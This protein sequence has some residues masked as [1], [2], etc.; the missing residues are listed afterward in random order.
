MAVQLALAVSACSR[1]VPDVLQPLQAQLPPDVG[2]GPKVNVLPA[3]TLAV[4]VFKTTYAV[5]RLGVRV[6]FTAVPPGFIKEIAAY[7]GPI[8]AVVVVTMWTGS[9][10][11]FGP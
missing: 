4:A 8:F 9:L 5:T 6:G 10:T 7:A 11:P 3:A 1:A 2:C